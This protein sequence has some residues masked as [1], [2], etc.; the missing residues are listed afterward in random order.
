[1]TLPDSYRDQT[2]ANGNNCANKSLKF[3]NLEFGT[4]LY[5]GICSLVLNIILYCFF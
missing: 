1:M 4:Y 3:K 5:F 2:P